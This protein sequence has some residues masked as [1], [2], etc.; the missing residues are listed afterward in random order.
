MQMGVTAVG[1]SG[2]PLVIAEL[3]L[4]RSDV[5]EAEERALD[6]PVGRMDTFVDVVR[7]NGLAYWLRLR[8]GSENS[9]HW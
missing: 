6:F 3:R 1:K 2:G 5:L 8:I 9:Q 4:G 7:R